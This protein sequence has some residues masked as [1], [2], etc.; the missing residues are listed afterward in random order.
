MMKG[1]QRIILGALLALLLLSLGAVWLTHGWAN[2]RDRLRAIRSASKNSSDRVDTRALDMAQQVADLAVTR[3]EQEYAQSALRLADHSVDLAF[4]AA[5]EN[6][7]ENPPPLTPET[8]QITGHIQAAETSVAAD[9]DHVAKLTAR[10]AK[11]RGSRKSALQGQLDLAQAQLSLDQDELADA[12]Q[13][14]IR[15]GGDRRA[16]IQAQLDQHEA[17]ATHDESVRALASANANA[18]T[19]APS[20]ELV[21]SASLLPQLKAW[22]SLRAKEKLI[23][24]AQQNAIDRGATLST[25]HDALEKELDEEEAQ[26]KII[27]RNATETAG[28]ANAPPANGP[29]QP[30]SDLALLTHLANGRKALSELNQQIQDEKELTA[31][32]S[33]W[34]AFVNV[35]KQAFVH[36]LLVSGFWIVLIGLFIFLANEGVQHLFGALTP[37]RQ[38]L[39]TMRAVSLFGVQ[40]LGVVLILLVIFGVPS[41]FATLAALAGAGLTIALKDFI[42]GFFGW[43][44]L[45]GKNGIRPGDWVEINGIGGEVVSVGPL[46]TVLL[47]T[48]SW[49][50]AGHPTGRKVTFVNSFAIEGHYFNFSTSGQWLWDELQVL[51][52]PGSDPYVLAETIQKMAA[53]DSAANAKLAEQ[54]WNR[55]TPNNAQRAFSAT[56]SMIVRPTEYGMSILVRYITRANE[57]HDVR[58]RLYRAIVELLQKQVSQA[59]TE[60]PVS[61]SAPGRT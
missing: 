47:E 13:D 38:E 6:A 50:D 21:Q 7:A 49:S 25:S 42:V 8:R 57:R 19:A 33:D 43:F 37:E 9:Q 5:L 30:E 53:D 40:A 39:H 59:A 16:G 2:Y 3:T 51:A 55:V 58:A 29:A 18:A 1:R 45:M 61:V 56:P 36:G 46:H 15:A 17:A 48:G 32:Y 23:L 35:R 60:K 27:H 11:A 28:P 14:L 54:E 26:K 4:A 10:L 41:N 12:H 24:Q 31:V 22:L 44:I 52:P 34:L 20:I